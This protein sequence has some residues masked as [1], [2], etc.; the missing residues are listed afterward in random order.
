LLTATPLARNAPGLLL[1]VALLLPARLEGQASGAVSG[2]VLVDS[3]T[4]LS[5]ARIRVVGITTVILSGDDGRFSL[6]AIP[7]GS[8]VL[9]VRRIG[10]V[11]SVQGVKIVAGETLDLQITLA[12]VPVSLKAVEVKGRPALLP[13]MQGFEHRRTHGNGHFL[14]RTEIARMQSRVFTDVLGR[15]RPGMMM[16]RWR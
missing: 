10:Y 8:Q 16:L 12:L 9:E 6:A 13:A 15:I 1:A 7:A 4:P 2:R 5:Q 3:V 14:N 11:E